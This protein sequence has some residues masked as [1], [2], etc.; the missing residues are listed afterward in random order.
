MKGKEGRE[1]SKIELIID[2]YS[3]IIIVCVFGFG[4]GGILM[5]IVVFFLLF[6]GP[7]EY[8]WKAK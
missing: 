4:W 2:I 5:L 8:Q 7:R 3:F 6:S 1:M